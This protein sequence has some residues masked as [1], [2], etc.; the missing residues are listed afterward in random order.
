VKPLFAALIIAV[1]TVAAPAPVVKAAAGS[2]DIVTPS[3]AS[4]TPDSTIQ[5]S[6][7]ARGAAVSVTQ[8]V[9][10][11]NDEMTGK[12]MTALKPLVKEIP[13]DPESAKTVELTFS[14]QVVPNAVSG[15]GSLV[16]LYHSA[17]SPIV[18]TKG[19]EFTVLRSAPDVMVASNP[20]PVVRGIPFQTV[21]LRATDGSPACVQYSLPSTTPVL[22]QK[23]KVPGMLV[24]P[25]SQSLGSIA[26]TVVGQQ[27]CLGATIPALYTQL[28]GTLWLRPPNVKKPIDVAIDLRVRDSAKWRA[29]AAAMSAGLGLMLVVWSSIVRRRLLNQASR[30][31]L[32]S[33]LAQFLTANPSFEAGSSSHPLS[34]W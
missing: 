29:S 10:N 18:T 4:V 33:R 15:K 5:L 11:L 6:L 12:W 28:K 1:Q 8:V 19:W 2:L 22:P 23:L 24:G 27:L 9:A 3:G 26:A 25:E 20:I 14:D 31:D 17:G 13:L 30:D 32:T 34:A 21:E 16:L 7:V